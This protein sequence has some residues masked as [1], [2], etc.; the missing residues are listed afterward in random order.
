MEFNKNGEI[1]TGRILVTVLVVFIITVIAIVNLSPLTPTE[2]AVIN[3]IHT[4]RLI[5]VVKKLEPSQIVQYDNKYFVVRTIGRGGV[6][7]DDLG[8]RK[9]QLNFDGSNLLGRLDY[10]VIRPNESTYGCF[11]SNIIVNMTKNQSN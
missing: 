2:Q 9:E 3:Q 6:I 5:E 8:G 10:R 1:D 7:I 11:A 4:D